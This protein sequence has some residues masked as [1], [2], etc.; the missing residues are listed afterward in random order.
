MALIN[1][2]PAI[3]RE[4]SGVLAAASYRMA[5]PVIAALVLVGAGTPAHAS[6]LIT[7]TF[8]TSITSDP[9]AVAI[10]GAINGAISTIEGDIASP[11]N[12]AVNLYFTETNTGLGGSETGIY[13]VSYFDYYNA[14][15]ALATSAVQLA[16]LT[17]LGPA[18]TGPSSGNPVDGSTLVDI[19]SAEGRNLGFNTPGTVAAPG[20][21]YD[22]VIS[23]NTSLT[24]PPGPNNG[25]NYGLEAVA[26]HEID[27]SLGIGGTGSTLTGSGAL[28]GAV[29]DLDLFRYSAPG[30]RSY[31][32][33]QTTS[34]YSYFSIDGGKTVLTY[35]NQTSGSD[36]A[37]WLSN[38][39]PAGFQPQVQD[40]FGEPGSNPV[41]GTNELLA[42]NAIGYDVLTPEPSSLVLFGSALTIFAVAGR[43]RIGLWKSR[44]ASS[45]LAE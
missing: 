16:A 42:L 38:P 31:S 19:T 29:G 41:L 45:P 4:T 36:F 13:T 8:G 3:T 27:E 9:G 43:R 30:V 18:P 24:Y 12:I 40:A 5:L 39:I 1:I 32:N 37:D 6:L 44:S 15:K 17:S 10:E 21:A 2:F 34:P 14:F 35:F 20:G 28:N 26:N 25:S 7:P 23:L 22:T 33:T 11:N